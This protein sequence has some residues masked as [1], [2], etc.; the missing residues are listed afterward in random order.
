VILTLRAKDA[1]GNNLTT[2]GLAVR[3]TVSGGTS[4]GTVGATT[5]QA[6]GTYTAVFTG[7]TAGTATTV[8]ATIGG[9]AVTSPLPTL[10]VTSGG[11]ATWPNEPPGFTR[12]TERAFNTEPPNG[13]AEDGWTY[14]YPPSSGVTIVSDPTAPKSPPYV[15]QSLF[16]T[17]FVAGAGP[18]D[19]ERYLTGTSNTQLYLA[20]WLKVS[21]NWYGEVNSGTNKI[22]FIWIHNAPTVYVKYEGSGN[23]PLYPAISTQT[24]PDGGVD[25]WSANANSTQ[26]I[27]RGQWH[28]W[29]VLLICNTAGNADGTIKWWVDGTLIG[30]HTNVPF[31]TASQGH[32]W[33]TVA[34]NPT[35]GGGGS[36]VPATQWQW[37]DH[38]YVSM[39]P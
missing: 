11:T 21:P 19:A 18:T 5:D 24:T 26:Q 20:F 4:T 6:N 10:T 1:N 2:G 7:T 9:V 37:M 35:Y 3:F 39:R 34:W 12:F 13:A 33:Q 22:F 14:E 30:S 17:G 8:H 28:F 32:V 27:V 29:E 36:T 38:V 23:G 25:P 31:S 16:P 15:G